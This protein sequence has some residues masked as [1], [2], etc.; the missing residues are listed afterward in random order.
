MASSEKTQVTIVGLGLVGASA[1]LALRRYTDRVVI[2]GHDKD[3]GIANQA[4]SKG[5]IDR[6]EWNLIN[7]VRN[8]DRIL[9]AVSAREV[10]ETL[11]FIKDDLKPNCVIVDT[12]NVKA[13]V[14][15]W[16]AETLPSHAG[17]VGGHPILLSET[18]ETASAR[19]DL[20]QNKVFCLTADSRTSPESL[21]L[22]TDLVEALGAKPFFVDPA[23]HDGLVAAVEQLPALVAGALARAA[24]TSGSWREMRKLAGSQF[25]AGTY[26]VEA[27]ARAAAE[28]CLANDRNTVRWIDNLIAE[29]GQWR[30]LV[31]TGEQDGLA[32]AFEQAMSL[33][34]QWTHAQE[35]G[36]WDAAPNMELPSMSSHLRRM[37]GF[38]GR[39]FRDTP[40][41]SGSRG[42]GK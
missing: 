12:A 13:P 24:G 8:A 39:D 11:G 7:A 32:K 22:A 10:R 27:E 25:Y 29:L 6:A 1:G 3:T 20:F 36:T 15:A 18:Q 37:I 21:Q 28:S 33:T 42:K 26:I 38:G 9:L 31:E 40:G 30:Q 5:A 2:V 19:A 4:K 34:L 17:F 14:L 41:G 35:T 23:E 16:A